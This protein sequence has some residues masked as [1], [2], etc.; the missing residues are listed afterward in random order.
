MVVSQML[1]CSEG[2]NPPHTRPESCHMVVS[3][4]GNDIFLQVLISNQ[5][6]GDFWSLS[7]LGREEKMFL[8][9]DSRERAQQDEESASHRGTA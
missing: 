1:C 3:G 4:E 8:C 5:S 6:S 9:V 7:E 2:F